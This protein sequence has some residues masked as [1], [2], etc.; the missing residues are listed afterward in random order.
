MTTLKGVRSVAPCELLVTLT[1]RYSS[2]IM[3]ELL[4]ELFGLFFLKGELL[5]LLVEVE[6]VDFFM[7]FGDWVLEVFLDW[8]WDT[9]T[10]EWASRS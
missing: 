1:M 2:W 9:Q 4:G 8:E 5:P 6:L 10:L 3:A 7:D